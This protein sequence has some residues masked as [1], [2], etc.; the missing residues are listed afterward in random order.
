MKITKK[1]EVPA[2]VEDVVVGLECD[3]CGKVVQRDRWGYETSEIDEV[4]VKITMRRKTGESW[5]DGGFQKEQ[6]I[7]ICPQCWDETI[8]PFLK[9]KGV[10]PEIVESEW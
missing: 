3:M 1:H 5:P 4:L 6:E 8:A 10:D 7:D 9:S 2:R